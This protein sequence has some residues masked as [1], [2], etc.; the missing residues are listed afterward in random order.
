MK[1]WI[2]ASTIARG[3]DIP[4]GSYDTR[5]EYRKANDYYWQLRASQSDD[6]DDIKYFVNSPDSED[7]YNV[8]KNPYTP[9]DLLIQLCSDSDKYVRKAAKMQLDTLRSTG[10][11]HWK[12]EYIRKGNVFDYNMYILDED[13]SINLDDD[14]VRANH[15]KAKQA[16]GKR[17]NSSSRWP[18]KSFWDEMAEIED[19]DEFFDAFE[20]AQ[21]TY[22]INIISNVEDELEVFTES[23]TRGHHGT[24]DFSDASGQDRFKPF[25]IDVDDLDLNVF[26]LARDSRNKKEF[27]DNYRMYLTDLINQN[28]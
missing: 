6:L 17:P 16:K 1:R 26:N 8:A 25:S 24:I 2:H 21:Q 11:R 13:G 15:L 23:S 22:L 12:A 9:E 5:R 28:K 3:R 27:N 18:G 20:D 19:D 4:L 14:L 7:R 10:E